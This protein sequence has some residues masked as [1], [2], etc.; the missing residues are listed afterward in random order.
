[1]NGF[2]R[3]DVLT[4]PGRSSA[5]A[6]TA[7]W[8]LW[9]AQWWD[10]VQAIGTLAAVVV[11]LGLAGWEGF[12]LRAARRELAEVKAAE[13]TRLEEQQAS[14]VSAWIESDFVPSEDGSHYTHEATVHVANEGNEPVY[15]VHVVIGAGV[16]VTQLGPLSVPVPIPVLP[17]R[18]SRSWNISLPLLATSSAVGL[19]PGELVARIDFSD[20]RGER[21]HRNFEGVLGRGADEPGQLFTEDTETG[22]SQLGDLSN[23]F[24]PMQVAGAFWA[25]AISDDPPPVDEI[26]VTL[27]STASAWADLDEA[28]WAEMRS[29][30][31]GYGL[32]AHVYYPAPR[33]A[34]VRLVH[35]DDQSKEVAESGF[36]EVRAQVITLV[37][38]AGQGWR[39]FSVGGGATRPDWIGFPQGSLTRD[40]REGA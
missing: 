8:Q 36:V 9:G 37:F 6:S 13:A 30:I 15:S 12:R 20:I 38:L 31:S 16:P 19:I 22:E 21:W 34:Y 28:S 33:V 4:L 25:A 5:N 3:L 2:V 26:R 7:V 18:R 23:A 11:A 17:P 24:N 27:A 1:M 35:E 40:V 32:A 39:I 29:S 10:A 14:L